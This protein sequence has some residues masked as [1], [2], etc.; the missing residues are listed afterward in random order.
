MRW[1]LIAPLALLAACDDGPTAAEQQAQDERDVAAVEAAQTPPP[2]AINPQKILYSDIERANLFGA[3]CSFA[4]DG[5]GMGAIVLAKGE[6][7][8]MKLDGEIVRF[9]PDTG[10]VQ[11][12]L[13]AWSKYTGKEN[14]F[15]LVLDE[16][17]GEQSGM[18]TVAFGAELTVRDERDQVVY[19]KRGV[20][21]C[22]S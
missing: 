15:R 14:S 1:L 5:G 21:Q 17:D 22:G 6:A 2:L 19:Q 4:P 7:G 20:A 9:A 13:D 3:G 11:L 12:P 18:E 10:S 8:Y 16:G